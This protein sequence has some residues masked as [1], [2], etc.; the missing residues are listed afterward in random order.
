MKLT[1]WGMTAVLALA[2]PN[3]AWAWE[4]ECKPQFDSFAQVTAAAKKGNA[5]AQYWL[6]EAYFDGESQFE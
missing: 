6:G 2:L 5:E 4:Q 1:S 3:A